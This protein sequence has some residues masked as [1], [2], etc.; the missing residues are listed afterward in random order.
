M[1]LENQGSLNIYIPQGSLSFGDNTVDYVTIPSSEYNTVS[2]SF[3]IACW[4]NTKNFGN[5]S[6][7]GRIFCKLKDDGT[8]GS[9][10]YISSNRTNPS[11]SHYFFRVS[12]GGGTADIS[13]MGVGLDMNGTKVIFNKW[14][15]LTGTFNSATNK[16]SIYVD[17]DYIDS[18][19]T[20]SGACGWDDS[21]LYFG[22]FVVTKSFSGQI[23]N[24]I[25][26]SG[27]CLTD[28]EVKKLYNG[29]YNSNFIVGNYKF[30]DKEGS[31]LS[32]SSD[33]SQDGTITGA[34]WENRNIQCWCTRWDEGN[35]DLSLEGMFNASDRNYLFDNVTPGATKEQFTILGTKIFIDTTYTSSNSLIIEPQG[36][37]G[38]SSIR[39]NRVIAVKSIS[40]NFVNNSIYSVKIEG[41]IL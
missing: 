27:I 38:I 31:T 2:N 30:N 35:W 29:N 40:D 36:G 37:F 10:L 28:K 17:G 11:N 18:N 4:L 34:D 6:G 26:I 21:G 15:H 25:L 1:V 8:A 7:V 32:D 12:G 41:N 5:R 23:C 19:T 16:Q 3:S 24:G 20:T 14:T 9:G 39:K 13:R 33:Y 22:S